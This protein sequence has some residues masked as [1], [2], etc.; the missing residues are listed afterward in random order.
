[1]FIEFGPSYFQYM[2]NVVYNGY[3]SVIAKILAA[4]SIKTTRVGNERKVY[5]LVLE[6]LN[7]GINPSDEKYIMRYDL[8]GSEVNRF[9][10]KSEAKVHLDSNF[11]L[12]MNGRPILIDKKLSNLL[13]ISLNNDSLCLA[14]SNRI[15][16]SLLAVVNRKD[17]WIR[18]GLIDYLQSYTIQRILESNFKK[19]LNMGTRPTIIEPKDYRL[20]FIKFL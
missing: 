19:I 14:N 12:S 2:R 3:P 9:V 18:F 7:L 11:L 4:Y 16:Y 6:N 5:V 10:N 8:K 17:K 20:R 15:D 1:M 13:H